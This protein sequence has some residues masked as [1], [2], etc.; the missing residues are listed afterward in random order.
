MPKEQFQYLQFQ[1]FFEFFQSQINHTKNRTEALGK[2]QLSLSC[3]QVKN[4]ISH[5]LQ[6]QVSIKLFFQ[7]FFLTASLTPPQQQ[8]MF[9]LYL[10][11]LR[12]LQYHSALGL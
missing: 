5:Q 6:Q 3:R 10:R 1:S 7:F 8:E 2:D 4:L 11:A 9:F 12:K